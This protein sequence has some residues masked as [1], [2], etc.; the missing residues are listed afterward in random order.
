MVS[1]QVYLVFLTPVCLCDLLISSDST[2]L[3]DPSHIHSY[4]F[5]MVV[6][7]YPDKQEYLSV[8]KMLLLV[9]L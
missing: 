4:I 6:E 9:S 8:N 3:L 2:V 7:N 1:I 5:V